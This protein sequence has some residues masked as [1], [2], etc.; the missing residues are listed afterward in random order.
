MNKK[1]LIS[2]YGSIGRRHAAVLSKF[3]KREN[4]IILTKQKIHNF[5]T[6]KSLQE[7]K[8]LTHII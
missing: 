4:I 8:K 6:I 3:I 5:R 2:G 7:L 1:I